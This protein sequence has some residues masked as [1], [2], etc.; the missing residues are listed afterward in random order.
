MTCVVV[1][2]TTIRNWVVRGF[3]RSTTSTRV[4]CNDAQFFRRKSWNDFENVPLIAT[5]FG[6]PPVLSF[7]EGEVGGRVELRPLDFQAFHLTSIF[8]KLMIGNEGFRRFHGLESRHQM[9]GSD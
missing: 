9:T 3:G 6:S 8:C 5:I 2:M 4:H 1:A 7:R